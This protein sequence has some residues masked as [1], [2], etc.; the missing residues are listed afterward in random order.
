LYPS[1]SSVAMK[2]IWILND[3]FVSESSRNNGIARHLMLA[4]EKQAKLKDIFSIKLA[5]GIEN[6]KAQALYH[7]LN[8]KLNNDFEFFSKRIE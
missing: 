5:T 2:P 8:Y 1:Y 4:V 7:S 3:L 6:K